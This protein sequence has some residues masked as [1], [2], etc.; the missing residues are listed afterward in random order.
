MAQAEQ[1]TRGH[2][3]RGHSEPGADAAAPG[4]ERTRAR[5]ECEPSQSRWTQPVFHART[6]HTRPMPACV[7]NGV[8]IRSVRDRTGRAGT[9]LRGS[10]GDRLSGCASAAV[11]SRELWPDSCDFER[12]RVGKYNRLG[13]TDRGGF[14]DHRHR[15]L[16][17]PS[18]SK[19]R[20]NSRV[21]PNVRPRWARV[22]PEVSRSGRYGTTQD[23]ASGPL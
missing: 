13:I 23:P 22:S 11:R 3:K 14:Q 21:L 19:C 2:D 6:A 1:H 9:K 8:T 12:D 7:T 10:I 15:P 5:T 18:A 20:R 16:G 17:H 4:I